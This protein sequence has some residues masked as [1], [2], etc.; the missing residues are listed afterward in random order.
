MQVSYE[1][2]RDLISIVMTSLAGVI[3]WVLSKRHSRKQQKLDLESKLMVQLDKI[4]EKYVEMHTKF[5]SLQEVLTDIKA[6]NRELQTNINSLTVK[7]E[8]LQVMIENLTKE[9][10][11]LQKLV[12]DF[13]STQPINN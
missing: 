4:S 8:R 13:S 3:A 10:A 12:K 11:H 7:N 2:I 1:K 9:N 5:H 6:Q